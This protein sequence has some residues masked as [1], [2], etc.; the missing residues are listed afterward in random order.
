MKIWLRE[1]HINEHIKLECNDEDVAADFL[2]Q[3]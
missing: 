3:E 1:I 2:Q